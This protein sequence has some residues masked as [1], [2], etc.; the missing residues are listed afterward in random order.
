[1]QEEKLLGSCRQLRTALGLLPPSHVVD[2]LPRLLRDVTAVFEHDP[3][4][5]A[6]AVLAD[7]FP[8]AIGAARPTPRPHR[9]RE[10][11]DQLRIG[12]KE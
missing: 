3:G 9:G 8:P 12:N 10:A 7:N 11:T 1:M 6:A 2:A 5:V 4:H